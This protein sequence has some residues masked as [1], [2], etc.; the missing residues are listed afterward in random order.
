M[1]EGFLWV[2][3]IAV[4]IAALILDLFV[5]QRK[6][7][8]IPVKEALK[9]VLFWFT[10]AMG[11]LALVWVVEGPAKGV[12]FL[13]AYLVEYSLSIDNLFV[14]LALFTY[15]V[16]P[17]EAQR[18]VLLWG[19]LGAIFFRGIFI[20]VGIAAI[21]KW[22]FLMYVLGVIL[23]YTA[24]KLITQKEKEVDPE[25]NPVVR[26]TRKFIRVDPQYDGSKFFKRKDGLLYA[27]PLVIVLVTIETM[28]VMFAVDS[29][30]AVFGITLDPFIV[31]TSN[32]FA[33]LGLRALFFA[34]AGLFYLFRYLVYGLS[35]VLAFVGVKMLIVHWYKMPVLLSLAVVVGLILGSVLLSIIL[36]K[37][38]TKESDKTPVV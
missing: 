31:Y 30:P 38:E 27:T 21:E 18:K 5:F 4:F 3:F 2:I 19:I 29:V 7:H 25:K 13:T 14:F 9:L 11:F 37:K 36:P 10:I 8:I 34:L 33:I 24:F 35:I 26:L 1:G 32:V 22:S 23:I 6:A 16:V 28:D 17:R 15:F 20:F 12:E